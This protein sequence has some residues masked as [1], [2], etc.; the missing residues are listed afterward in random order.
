MKR[1]ENNQY[2]ISKLNHDFKD[3]NYISNIMWTVVVV[4]ADFTSVG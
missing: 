2:A 1:D 4:K 3:F